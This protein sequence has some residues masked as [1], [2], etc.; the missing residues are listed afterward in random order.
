MQMLGAESRRLTGM[1]REEPSDPWKEIPSLGPKACWRC[2][3]DVSFLREAEG[4]G[5]QIASTILGS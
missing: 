4:I 2:V 5:S 3:L 1:G